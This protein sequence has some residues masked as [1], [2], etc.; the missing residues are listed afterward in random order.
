MAR[1]R[2]LARP[3]PALTICMAI[4]FSTL[5]FIKGGPCKTLAHWAA[6]TA[7]GRPST[8]SELSPVRQ[9]LPQGTAWPSSEVQAA[10]AL[11]AGLGNPGSG[12]YALNSHG[13]A[14][15]WANTPFYDPQAFLSSGGSAFDLGTF[16]GGQQSA[17]YSI[18]D[19]GFIVGGADVPN[20]SDPTS[21]FFH[22]CLF[23]NGGVTDL[24]TLGGS[25][26]G[27]Y[28]VNVFQQ[29]V[30][31]ADRTAAGRPQAFIWQNGVIQNLNDMIPATAA[32]H[33]DQANGINNSGQIVGYGSLSSGDTHAF[34]LTPFLMLRPAYVPGGAVSTATITLDAPAPP[35]GAIV[36][37]SSDSALAVLSTPSV[38]LPP[39]TRTATFTV[40]TAFVAT[41]T[42]VHITA[43][44][45]GVTRTAP[46]LIRAAA[47]LSGV[48][49]LEGCVAM[50]GEIVTLIFRNTD[51]SGFFT[52]T[53]TL[54]SNGSFS[55]SNVPAGTYY[56]AVKGRL[57]LQK[58]VPLD[59]PDNG[60]PTVAVT[61]LTG[62][63]NNDNSVDTTDFGIFVSAYN[64]D[65]SIPG[66]GYDTRAD[67]NCDGF[68]DPTD[69]GL[70]VDNYNTAGDP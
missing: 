5:S 67:F 47:T 24:G 69:F 15:G 59:A 4:P 53:A 3:T 31:Y 63:S 64:T 56:L 25:R 13:Q 22:A 52:R 61:L 23:S 68:V 50:G 9:T 40:T 12:A 2:S 20:N 62:D 39:G 19:N 46:L 42:T 26:S 55:L 41:D 16:S 51:D 37:L 1:G 48:V 33:L 7:T 66:S 35:T 45:L 70:F 49:T 60:T 28:S 57:W 30:G 43:T 18:T 11:S 34:L 38:T 10:S 6:T 36:T 58:V 17:A 21:P 65:R 27:A 14:V 29:I 54:A 32:L 8:R 44:Y